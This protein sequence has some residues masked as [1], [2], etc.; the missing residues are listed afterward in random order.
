[1][2]WFKELCCHFR[3]GQACKPQFAQNKTQTFGLN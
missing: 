2:T 1:M 3:R